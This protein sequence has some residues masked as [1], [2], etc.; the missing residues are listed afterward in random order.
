[1]SAVGNFMVTSISFHTL[2]L[3]LLPTEFTDLVFEVHLDPMSAPTVV[4]EVYRHFAFYW[5]SE[6]VS[7]RKN[8]LR[9][10]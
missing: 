9:L 3:R 6:S 7:L 4:Y 2:L 8:N 5:L 10:T 1:M